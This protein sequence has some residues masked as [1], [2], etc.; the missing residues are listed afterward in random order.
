M[1][2]R[3]LLALLL[4][5]LLG[6]ARRVPPRSGLGLRALSWGLLAGL[7][8]GLAAA[9]PLGGLGPG[10]REEAFALFVLFA[11]GLA[12]LT[13]RTR[14]TRQGS[15]QGSAMALGFALACVV[16][17]WAA[18]EAASWGILALAALG[19]GL[20]L[21]GLEGEASS[22]WQQALPSAGV[23]LSFLLSAFL[24]PG[25]AVAGFSVFALGAWVGWLML[26]QAKL[27]PRAWG[28]VLV[29]SGAGLGLSLALA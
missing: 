10:R 27:E 23:L 19:V 22:W 7:L 14:L 21:R 25:R 18:D 20:A 6:L 28:L 9:L 3:L 11:A 4:A 1:L 24:P 16:G 17:A 26:S 15:R 13:W 8:L 12:S 29:G 2:A 5:A